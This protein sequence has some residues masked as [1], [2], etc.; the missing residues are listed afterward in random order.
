MKIFTLNLWDK[1]EYKYN[2]FT[3]FIPTITCYINGTRKEKP[4]ILVV[5]GGGYNAVS[6]SEAEVVA[7]K[8]L[9]KGYNAFVLTYS[10]RGSKK[11]EPVKLN[12]LRDIAKA[13]VM[14]KQNAVE[15]NVDINKISTIGFSAGGHLCA[16][17]SVHHDKPFL[18]DIK[19]G[20]DIKPYAQIL[21]YP[22]ISTTEKFTHDGSKNC[23][24]GE[25]ATKED[26]DFMSVEKHVAEHT[27]KTFLWHCMDDLSVSYE[28]SIA[29]SNGLNKAGIP[30]ELH[31]FPYG[32]HGISTADKSFATTSYDTNSDTF[33]L[34]RKLFEREM[35]VRDGVFVSKEGIDISDIKTYDEYLEKLT[36]MR[37][38]E[39]IGTKEYNHISKWVEL[40]IEW[41]EL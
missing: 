30:F 39:K 11:M 33:Q 6:P 3:D 21:C 40:A 37:K 5:P 18:D 12:A 34:N 14:I 35:K 26:I 7:M 16:S 27:P 13:I 4:S 38:Y 20:L 36:Q 8:F 9:E 23:L 32:A 24:L 19:K 22:V 31:V 15:W 41:L 29:F 2:T 10:V 28:N 25:N 1:D 17:L